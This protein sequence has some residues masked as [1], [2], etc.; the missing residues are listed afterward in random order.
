M[1]GVDLLLDTNAVI[2]WTNND[3]AILRI[4]DHA[5]RIGISVFT[6]GELEYGAFKS[7]HVRANL[8]LVEKVLRGVVLVMPDRD[9]ATVYGSL[10][11]HL[12]AKARPIPE[13]DLW[14]AAAGEF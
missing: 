7:T 4:L 5:P 8:A 12:R 6:L 10:K 14:I 1:T 13:N 2:A 3:R 9:T 11:N